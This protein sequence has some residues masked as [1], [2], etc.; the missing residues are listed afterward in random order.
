MKKFGRMSTQNTFKLIT[1]GLPLMY[2]WDKFKK[3]KN[4]FDNLCNLYFIF[5]RHNNK[6]S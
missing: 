2:R 5:V 4:P 1:N 3:T 6:L